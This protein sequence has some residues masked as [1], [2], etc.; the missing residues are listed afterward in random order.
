[1]QFQWKSLKYLLLIRKWWFGCR[2]FQYSA[3]SVRT[4]SRNK[5]FLIDVWWWSYIH[6]KFDKYLI[7]FLLE[8]R[9][10]SLDLKNDEVVGLIFIFS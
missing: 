4:L 10:D 1:M 5:N 8:C 6:I 3:K 2:L 9:A 7:S